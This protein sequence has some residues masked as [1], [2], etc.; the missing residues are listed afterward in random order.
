MFAIIS[1]IL[2]VKG[3]NMI[4]INIIFV[5]FNLNE[6]YIILIIYA[7]NNCKVIMDTMVITLN[8]R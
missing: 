7:I 1:T 8:F 5:R 2:D 6:L 3:I 4:I